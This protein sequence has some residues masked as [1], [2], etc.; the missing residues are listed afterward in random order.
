MPRR[1]WPISTARKA[2]RRLHERNQPDARPHPRC[3]RRD[4]DPLRAGQD[5]RGRRRPGARRQP[6]LGL[7]ALRQQG[8][9][10]RRGDRTLARPRLGAPC[11]DRRRGWP[12]GAAPEAL[13]RPADRHQAAEGEGGAGAVRHLSRHLRGDRARSCTPM[14]STSPPR[15]RPSSPTASPAASSPTATRSR[16]AA[17]SSTPPPASTTPAYARE[18]EDP[19]ID[20]AFDALWALILRGLAADRAAGDRQPAGRRA[21]AKK[22]PPARI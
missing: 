8:G 22:G 9:A 6:R 3:G 7:P 16:P 4:A 18:W 5:H 10:A 1:R 14:S 20:D 11:Q 21:N 13:V 17:P 19:G 12:G 15:S 2:A